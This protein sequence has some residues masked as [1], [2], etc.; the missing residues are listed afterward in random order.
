MALEL[1]VYADKTLASGG[2]L[3]NIIIVAA[4][5]RKDADAIIAQAVTTSGLTNYPQVGGTVQKFE[6]T[7]GTFN[8]LPA[9]QDQDT[10]AKGPGAPTNVPGILYEFRAYAA[11]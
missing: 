8:L 3:A 4:N 5:G 11:P 9:M 6:W 2:A 10:L 1:F 7:D